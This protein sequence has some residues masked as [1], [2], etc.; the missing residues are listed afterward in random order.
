MNKSGDSIE[1]EWKIHKGILV[2]DDVEYYINK[3]LGKEL[4]EIFTK[5]N[6]LVNGG[7]I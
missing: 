7:I 5:Y 3:T 4:Y 6:P 1:I 2:Y